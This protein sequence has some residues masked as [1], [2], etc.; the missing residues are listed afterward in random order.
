MK[1]C[2]TEAMKLIKELDEQKTQLIKKEYENCTVS[3]KEGE[4][5]IDNGYSYE[6]TR[7]DLK[8]LDR[9]IRELKTLL[10]QA[11]TKILIDKFSITIGEALVYLAQLQTEKDQ[12]E[13]LRA[14][15]Q[16]SRRITPNGVLEYTECQYDVK[17]VEEDILKVRTTINEVQIYRQVVGYLTSS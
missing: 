14:H 7:A 1:I 12:L 5:K 10:A 13:N 2:L 15:N 3:Y 17:K 9:K 16:I 8:E 6:T 4:A 11:N